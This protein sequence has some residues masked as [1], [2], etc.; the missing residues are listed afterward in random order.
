MID[1]KLESAISKLNEGLKGFST[2]IN[3][4]LTGVKESLSKLRTKSSTWC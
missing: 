4:S 3:N 1:T 2:N